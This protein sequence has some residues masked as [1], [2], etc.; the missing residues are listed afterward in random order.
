MFPWKSRTIYPEFCEAFSQWSVLREIPKNSTKYSH[1]TLR[2]IYAESCEKLPLN[3]FRDSPRILRSKSL[4]G[5]STEFW[6]QDSRK[7]MRGIPLSCWERFLQN[8]ENDSTRIMR[9]VTPE[10]CQN[11]SRI[12]KGNASEPWKILSQIPQRYSS[13]IIKEEFSQN[14]ERDSPRILREIPII[15]RRILLASWETFLQ[16][17]IPQDCK[18]NFL[19]ILGGIVPDSWEGFWPEAWEKFCL[20]PDNDYSWFAM[21]L[22]EVLLETP[23]QVPPLLS[24]LSCG[25]FGDCVRNKK[26]LPTR[27]IAAVKLLLWSSFMYF[28]SLWIIWEVFVELSQNFFWTPKSN[29]WINCSWGNAWGYFKRNS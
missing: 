3:L 25:C 16:T 18:R 6:E 17:E 11:S 5:I 22:R 19:K 9:K 20:N 26:K 28:F 21:I 12:L 29:F 4:I 7:I 24:S 8:A 10:S 14:P 2:D 13:K 1:R 27:V 23:R 15:L